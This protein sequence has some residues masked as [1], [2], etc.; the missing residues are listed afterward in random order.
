M[1]KMVLC[2]LLVGIFIGMALPVMAAQKMDI[3]IKNKP[4]TGYCKIVNGEVYLPLDKALVALGFG[5]RAKGDAIELYPEEDYQGVLAVNTD[6]IKLL[7]G[8]KGFDMRVT[9]FGDYGLVSLKMLAE[10]LDYKYRVTPQVGII[11]VYQVRKIATRPTKPTE[12]QGDEEK[13][14]TEKPIQLLNEEIYE[15]T[16]PI[17]P[18]EPWTLAQSSQ[19]R[20]TAKF[21]NKDSKRVEDITITLILL[22]G[23]GK[24]LDQIPYPPFSLG[25]G[26]EKALDVFWN[27]NTRIRANWK[28]K[29]KIGDEEAY[30]LKRLES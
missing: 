11:D 14:E 19:L 22:D 3:Y 17:N 21:I 18:Q 12:Q 13:S 16:P 7:I 23:Y 4:Y 2:I 15:D 6:S 28:W 8:R 27:N 20:G 24:P 29:V 10:N 26:E 30:F 5:W 25:P 1:K 9:R